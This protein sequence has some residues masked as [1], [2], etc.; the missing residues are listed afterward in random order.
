MLRNNLN[1]FN[2]NK[3]FSSLFIK[4]YKF[5]ILILL[6]KYIYMILNKFIK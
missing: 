1:K 4:T 3:L 5:Y 2:K 6:L